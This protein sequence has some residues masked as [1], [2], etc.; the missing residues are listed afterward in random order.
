MINDIENMLNSF[1]WERGNRN[2]GIQWMSWEN[3]ACIKKE[4]GLGFLDFKAFTMT[5]VAKQGLHLLTK[6]HALVSKIFKVRYCSIT[7]FFDV[8]LSYNPSFVWRSI[9]K[10]SE[11]LNLGC[12]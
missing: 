2:S 9:W 3:L 1:W 8:N 6:P 7:F 11:V 10:E 4:G 12:R 5:M